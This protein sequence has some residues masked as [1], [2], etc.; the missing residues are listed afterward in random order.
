PDPHTIDF[1]RVAESLR[2]QRPTLV[3]VDQSN[4]LFPL[5]VRTLVETTRRV[6]PETLV[7]VDCSHWLGLVLGGQ[8]PN[9][10]ALGADSFGGSTHKPFPGPQKA[11][12]A[13]NRSDLWSRLGKA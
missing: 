10:L 1:D 8:M 11:I 13:T 6:A 9:P 3:Y 2:D 7:H 12:V 5:D 4:C